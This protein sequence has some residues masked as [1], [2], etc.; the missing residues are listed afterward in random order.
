MWIMAFGRKAVIGRRM[1]VSGFRV[2]PGRLSGAPNMA[3]AGWVGGH[4]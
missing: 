3:Q 1:L 2:F 4:P